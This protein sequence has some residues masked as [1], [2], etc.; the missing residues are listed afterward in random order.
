MNTLARSLALLA[1][2]GHI[3][4]GISDAYARPGGGHGGHGAV[5]AVGAF[6]G[7]G[8]R[9]G[10]GGHGESDGDGHSPGHS[11]PSHSPSA[12]ASQDAGFSF[13]GFNAS[14]GACGFDLQLF[15]PGDYAQPIDRV[16]ALSEQ[17]Q[18]YMAFCGC[19][20][21]ACVADALDKY[22]D[23]LEQAT[24]A[25]PSAPGLAPHEVRK[26]PRAIRELPRIVHEAAARV[27]AAPTPHAAIKTLQT[28]IAFIQKKVEKTIA[29]MRA[30]DPDAQNLVTRGGDLVAGTLQSAATAL[31]RADTL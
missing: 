1:V 3:G 16:A 28:A 13:F 12:P 7:I 14:S 24:T 9:D 29:L 30:S 15:D 10:E 26:L 2:A 19:N 21:Q 20:T 4:L 27:R 22:A 23:A 5:G 25:P 18:S 31:A 8:G 17:T 6:G 11:Q